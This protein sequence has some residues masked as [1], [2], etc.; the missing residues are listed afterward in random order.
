MFGRDE[1]YKILVGKLE[2]KKPLEILRRRWEDSLRMDLS[3]REWE[4]VDWMH[5][6]QVRD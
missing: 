6:A 3:K 1:K 5:L 4:G 2:G